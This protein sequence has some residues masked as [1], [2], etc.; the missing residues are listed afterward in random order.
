MG[1]HKSLNSRIRIPFFSVALIAADMEV[2]IGKERS[3]LSQKLAQKLICAFASGVH[4][5]IENSPTRFNLVGPCSA[6]ELRIPDK[7]GS[8]MTRHVKF[9]DHSDSPLTRVLDHF[10]NLLLRVIQAVGTLL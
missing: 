1:F 10:A 8:S 3:H 5:G 9:R 2:S 7:P 6:G 4:R